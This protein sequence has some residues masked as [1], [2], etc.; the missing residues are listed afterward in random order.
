MTTSAVIPIKQLSNAKQRLSGLLD[1]EERKALFKAM[2]ED[3]LTAVEACTEVDQIVVVTDDHAVAELV[4]G[5][6][7]EV[8]PEPQQPGLIEAV[9]ESGVQLADEGVDVMIFLPGDVPLVSAD[10]LAVV[11]EGFGAGEAPE[12]LIVPAA[13]LG[14]SNCVVV[15]PPDCMTFGFGEDSFRRHLAIARD[16]GIN[17]MVAKLPGIG[18]DVDTP[19]D[20]QALQALVEQDGQASREQY[21]EYSTV[22]FL[23][24]SGIFDRLNSHLAEQN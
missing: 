6:G 5:Y 7:A 16:L 10:E 21:R 22:R 24:S 19:D 8:R 11:L 20:L 4:R 12:F 2:V 23:T 14:G 13:D 9:T 18:L 15:S 1:E 17:P 3:V